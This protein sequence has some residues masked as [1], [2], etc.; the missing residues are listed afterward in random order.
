FREATNRAPLPE[1]LAVWNAHQKLVNGMSLGEM[2]I[3][4]G[5]R[6][7]PNVGVTRFEYFRRF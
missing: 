7:Y 1:V 6:P 2:R 4:H 3:I 5:V